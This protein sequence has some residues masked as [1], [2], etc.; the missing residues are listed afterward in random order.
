MILLQGSENF[1]SLPVFLFLLS[2]YSLVPGKSDHITDLRT[3]GLKETFRNTVSSPGRNKLVSLNKPLL[4]HKIR[5][6]ALSYF[7]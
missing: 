1:N 3:K 2:L 7:H 6:L 4:L 5:T